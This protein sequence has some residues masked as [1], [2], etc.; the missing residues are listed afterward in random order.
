VRRRFREA[1]L[2]LWQSMI[3]DEKYAFKKEQAQ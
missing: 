2:L 3:E 1:V